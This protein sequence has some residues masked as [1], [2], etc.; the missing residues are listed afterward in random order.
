MAGAGPAGS[1]SDRVSRSLEAGCEAVLLCRPESVRA[2]LA[3]RRSWPTPPTGRLESLYGR[4]M[5]SLEEQM[6][7]PE[8]RAWRDALRALS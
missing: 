7:V 1:L 5:A 8:F 6:L 2:V 3:E 4:A